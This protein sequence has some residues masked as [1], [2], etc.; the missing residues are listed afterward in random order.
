MAGRLE[1]QPARREGESRLSG[2]QAHA[3]MHALPLVLR[4]ICWLLSVSHHTASLMRTQHKDDTTN[5]HAVRG[6]VDEAGR[7]C[8][9]AISMTRVVFPVI[10]HIRTHIYVIGFM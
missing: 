6:V 1:Q 2:A 3:L 8:S 7:R 9:P 5:G 4:F 10:T